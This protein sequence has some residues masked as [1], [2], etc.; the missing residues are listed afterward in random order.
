MNWGSIGS[1]NGLAPN[2]R[3]AIIWTNAGI[4]LIEPL[5][6]K[7]SNILIEIH[8]FSFKKMHLKM[9]SAKWW[10]FCVVEMSWKLCENNN[11]KGKIYIRFLK[12]LTHGE[13][14]WNYKSNFQAK[15]SD[16]CLGYFLWNCPQMNVTE[17]LI[18]QH[19]YRWW[20]GSVREP[21]IIWARIDPNLCRHMMLLG[22]NDNDLN[23]TPHMMYG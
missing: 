16:L 3:Q 14:E 21:A 20:L 23:L 1:D 9:S 12:S 19:C 7:M 13:F 6:T 15:L 22:Y 5:G 10:P 17:P 2:R 8:I 11:N 4:L 18:S